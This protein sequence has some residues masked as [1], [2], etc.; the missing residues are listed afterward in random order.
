MSIV[1]VLA[2]SGKNKQFENE[3][4]DCEQEDSEEEKLQQEF[5]ARLEHLDDLLLVR[6]IRIMSNFLENNAVP[7]TELVADLLRYIP[8]VTNRIEHLLKEHKIPSVNA[9]IAIQTVELLE[10]KHRADLR[11]LFS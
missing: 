1:S 10:Q 3:D 2:V 7:A 6:T 8:E 11:S 5:K 9:E 4:A